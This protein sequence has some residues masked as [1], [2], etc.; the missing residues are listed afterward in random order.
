MQSWFNTS[1]ITSRQMLTILDI[2]QSLKSI[3]TSKVAIA[4]WGVSCTLIRV[5]SIGYLC[6]ELASTTDYCERGSWLAGGLNRRRTARRVVWFMAH[7][8]GYEEA[9]DSDDLLP[10][11]D[12]VDEGTIGL[13]QVLICSWVSWE[14]KLV[15]WYL[16]MRKAKSWFARLAY[17]WLFLDIDL[18]T[19]EGKFERLV[20][21]RMVDE[22][23]V[24]Y[25]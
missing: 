18:M 25:F 22:G 12:K 7:S 24:W 4:G 11:A 5:P 6:L 2:C 8:T 21:A 23:W 15:Y 16:V 3:L 17:C 10:L 13:A 20:S 14:I 1:I 19:K 9:R